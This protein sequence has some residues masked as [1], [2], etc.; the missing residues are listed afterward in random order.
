MPDSESTL[1][2]IVTFKEH[3]APAFKALNLQWLQGHGLLEPEDLKY[4]DHPQ[5]T[6][7]D[8]GGQVFFALREGQI[9]GTCA[10]VPV[11]PTDWELVK[12]AVPPSEQGKGL[13]RRLSMVAL[14]YA[15][16][17][18]AKK[19][20]LVS[21]SKLKA[22]IGLYESMGFQHVPMPP[23]IAYATADIYMELAL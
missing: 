3:Y 4:L 16:D 8:K 23:Q 6:I 13:G 21:S 9:V 1:A 17:H 20:V 7:L 5:E 19:A 10:V 15:N 22:A 18:G 2:E 12:L 14:A 11:S